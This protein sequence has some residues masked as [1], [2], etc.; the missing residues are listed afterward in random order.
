MKE[1]RYDTDIINSVVSVDKGNLYKNYL[2]I[3]ALQELKENPEFNQIMIVFK[4]VGNIIPEDFIFKFTEGLLTEKEE[5]ELYQKY[6]EVEEEV[7]KYIEE[8]NYKEALNRLLA[9]KRYID[10]FF[11]NVM[12][13]VK[14]DSIR[15][16]RLSLMKLIDNTFRKIADFT[17]ITTK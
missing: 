12:V 11:D 9:L 15:N 8:N 10:N 17:K 13:M 1:K 14:D 6:R 5:K 7:E 2:K 4:R 3:K 16:N